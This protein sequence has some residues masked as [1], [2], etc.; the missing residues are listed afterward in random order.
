MNSRET[1]AVVPCL[2]CKSKDRF[3]VMLNGVRQR[4]REEDEL[5]YCGT[6]SEANAKAAELAGGEPQPQDAQDKVDAAQAEH[7][8]LFPPRREDE[9]AKDF[10]V[11]ALSEHSNSHMDWVNYYK[12][13]PETQRTL[14][15]GHTKE[16]QERCVWRYNQIFA[17]LNELTEVLPTS[18]KCLQCGERNFKYDPATLGYSCT[19]LGCGNKVARLA[20]STPPA[21]SAPDD[22]QLW[23]WANELADNDGYTVDNL[24]EMGKR[25][26][27][28]ALSPAQAV[29]HKDKDGDCSVCGLPWENP[30]EFEFHECPPGFGQKPTP[31][32]AGVQAVAGEPP[33]CDNRNPCS[34][35][36]EFAKKFGFSA[37]SA[38]PAAAPPKEL[39]VQVLDAIE[40]IVGDDFC[41]CL[42]M[43]NAHR[44]FRG[45][46]M[47]M[48][49]KLSA[50]YRL[51]HAF[52]PN[53]S[54]REVHE[55]WRKEL[56]NYNATPA[57]QGEETS[58]EALFADLRSHL[59][60]KMSRAHLRVKET[61]KEESLKAF[62][63]GK[64]D[65]LQ[66]IFESG[67][68]KPLA[69]HTGDSPK[70]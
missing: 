8:R 67:Q 41:E 48:Y 49:D 30:A 39:L 3:G 24:I 5:V 18:S 46:K 15:D 19:T 68:W 45:D 34:C 29:P 23:H 62:N 56:Q 14:D 58:A 7:D 28:A 61:E 70:G 53:H 9:S 36:V 54:C 43:D 12:K 13:H 66:E 50:I 22:K 25:V 11:R 65:C 51:S 2:F 26:R 4:F 10:L 6:E 38:A 69:A 47:I 60:W 52:S 63:C 40:G 33:K 31:T 1:I 32:E 20:A 16:Y 27:A 42:S 35:E 21:A 59:E 64:V 57:P 55:D 44:K 17:A 37:P